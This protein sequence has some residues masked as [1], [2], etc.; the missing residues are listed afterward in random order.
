MIADI[1][2]IVRYEERSAAEGATED[3]S[4]SED[5]FVSFLKAESRRFLTETTALEA[6]HQTTF[7]LIRS[8]LLT[9]QTPALTWRRFEGELATFLKRRGVVTALLQTAQP[10]D[11]SLVVMPGTRIEVRPELLGGARLFTQGK[12]IDHTWS[13]RLRRLF[14]SSSV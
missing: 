5:R 10:T 13:S 14:S 1:R 12:V 7:S 4:L 2:R 9:S 11:L 6:L 3:A 8:R